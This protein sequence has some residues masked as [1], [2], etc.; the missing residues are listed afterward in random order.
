MCTS[1]SPLTILEKKF[2]QTVLKLKHRAFLLYRF[3]EILTPLHSLFLIECNVRLSSFLYFPDLFTWHCNFLK[4]W[5]I[6]G[7]YENYV[8]Y[9]LPGR[10]ICLVCE[11]IKS[12]FFVHLL[13]KTNENSDFKKVSSQTTAICKNQTKM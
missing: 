2:W 5:P 3:W 8:W 6:G 12:V 9:Y 13:R 7:Q 4:H 11:I 10:E 1:Q